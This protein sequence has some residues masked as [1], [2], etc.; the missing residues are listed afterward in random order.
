MKGWKK[1]REKAMKL[2][3]DS[4]MIC[5]LAIDLHKIENKVGVEG[6]KREQQKGIGKEKSFFG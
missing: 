2:N 6:R 5:R 4:V 3:V 1:K